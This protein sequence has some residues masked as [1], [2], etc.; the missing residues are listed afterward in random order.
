MLILVIFNQEGR[1]LLGDPWVHREGTS[2]S[3]SVRGSSISTPAGMKSRKIEERR[4]KG[5]IGKIQ[6]RTFEIG[7]WCFSRDSVN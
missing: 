4:V 2:A 1:E 6:L 5:R 7:G 3:Q